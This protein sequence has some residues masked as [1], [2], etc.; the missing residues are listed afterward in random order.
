MDAY[1]VR[2]YVAGVGQV[3]HC[4]TANHISGQNDVAMLMNKFPRGLVAI[5][6]KRDMRAP[7]G[8]RQIYRRTTE[9]R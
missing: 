8:W 1:R 2:A 9:G 3:C 6:E 5:V 4:S 7:T